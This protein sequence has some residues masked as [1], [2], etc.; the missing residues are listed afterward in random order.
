MSSKLNK[1]LSAKFRNLIRN[2][3]FM[4]FCYFIFFFSLAIAATI[5][6]DLELDRYEQSGLMELMEKSPWK[7]ALLAVVLAPILEEGIFRSLIR[8]TK[9]SIFFFFGCLFYTVGESVFPSEAN[10]ILVNA[11]LILSIFIFCLGLNELLPAENW[12]ILI[13]FLNRFKIPIW[14]VSALLFG[15]VHVFNY[16]EN[17][18]F[19]MVLFIM[20]FPRIIAGYFFGKIKMENKQM[21]WPILMHSM[22]N[23]IVILLTLPFQLKG[24]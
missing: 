11:I 8:P 2:F 6:P 10:W 17:I 4:I 16:V 7:F 15:F 13:R 12:K 1:D 9:T 18:Y 3:S 19:D 24:I 20:I 22:N 14:I 23:G 5:F 21:I